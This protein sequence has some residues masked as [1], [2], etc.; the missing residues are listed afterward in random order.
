[1]SGSGADGL[2]IAQRTA[3]TTLRGPLLVLAGAGSGKTRVITFRIAELIRSG[4]KPS[5]ILAV[6]FTNKA[7]KEM[8]ERTSSLLGRR[9]KNESGPEVSTFH[10][11]CVRVLRRHARLLGYPDH[12]SI[13]DRS[14]QESVARSALREVRVGQE[15]L[16]PSDLI[17]LVSGWKSQGIAAKDAEGLA[18]KDT[19]ILGALAY[20]RYEAQ[21]RASGA[22]DFDDLLL[23]T[24]RLFLNHPEARYAEQSRFDHVLIDEY[25]D[26][27]ALQYRIV[28]TLAQ[29]HRNLCV[30]G[31]D[32]QSIYGWR[33]AEVEH[34]LSFQNEWPEARVVRLEENYRSTEWI[35][36]LANTLI[37]HNKTRHDKVLRSVR[38][39]GAPPRFLAFEEED[40]EAEAI[41]SEIHQKIHREDEERV[42]A[43]DIAILF[44]T[45]EQPRAF[46]QALRRAGVPYVLVGGQSFFDRKEVKDLLCYLRVLANPNDEVS[47]LRVLNTPSRGIGTGSA[48]ALLNA[49]VSEGVPVWKVLHRAL[50][51]PDV[52]SNAASG[53][54]DFV[55]LIEEFRA[56][57]GVT[58]V[59]SLA[60]ELVR[61]VNYQAEIERLY[62][63]PSDQE[64]RMSSVEQ[65][66][67]SIASYER[68]ADSPSLI[69]FLEESSLASRDD[70]D[71]EDSR[72]EHSV[73]LM[74]LHSAKGLEFPEVYLVGLEEGLL[75]HKRS[76]I[77]QGS[78]IAEERRLAYVG[79]TRAQSLLTLSYSKQRMKWGKLREQLPSRF[80]LEMR[81]QT[82]K[83]NAIAAAAEEQLARQIE[84]FESQEPAG[85]KAKSS[86]TK[87][88][89]S[90]SEKAGTEGKPGVAASKG[91]ATPNRAATKSGR[92]APSIQ[93][94][95][96]PPVEAPRPATPNK[97][98]VSRAEIPRPA[99]VP[100]EP[101]PLEPVPLEPGEALP[102]VESNVPHKSGAGVPGAGG[103]SRVDG[104]APKAVPSPPLQTSLFGDS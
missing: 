73:T 91:P 6:T 8:R 31:D 50:S 67:N 5:R 100:P 41:A 53:V 12:F 70:D 84:R 9:K 16:R 39:R 25:Q 87:T 97:T 75:P 52:S 77:E 15:K 34:I 22:M 29:T 20:S 21:L 45:N 95:P 80:L 19:E 4:V 54:L 101:V 43:S 27:N 10:S 30:V 78:Q 55:A 37:A 60:A 17:Q 83:A 90:T 63:D 36:H 7:A 64:A 102:S 61:R 58:P 56:R 46:E 33:G 62:K 92:V 14:D 79:I 24:E 74:T 72:R 88:K 57:L 103:V 35:L 48:Q 94:R 82:D 49:A 76:V 65:F 81:G 3:V 42:K 93:S 96:A 98:S 89:A 86:K 13:Y 47:L 69:G 11:L 2:N 51:V 59:S 99:P 44:R 28:K 23:N 85:P 26:T 18:R 104:S 66:L 40:Q 38:G 71:D 68:K 1:M 32:D